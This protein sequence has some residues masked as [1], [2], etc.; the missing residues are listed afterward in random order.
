[1]S[2]E[3]IEE[4]AEPRLC[5]SASRGQEGA[6]PTD[7]ESQS[8]DGERKR[9]KRSR[10]DESPGARQFWGR[11]AAKTKQ[12]EKE[13]EKNKTPRSEDSALR[14]ERRPG[15]REIQD[16]MAR[17]PKRR[18]GERAG[19][20]TKKEKRA[21]QSDNDRKNT[22]AKRKPHSDPPGA[23]LNRKG[24]PAIIGLRDDKRQ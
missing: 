17:P 7:G 2:C 6:E 11:E 18:V 10:I 22:K 21:E 5:Q 3:G 14:G 20:K 13:K 9:K 15:N 16:Q 12:K 19:K 4:A 8:S 1:M 24:S 23:I